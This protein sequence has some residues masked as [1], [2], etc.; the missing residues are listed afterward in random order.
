MPT[1]KQDSSFSLTKM[2]RIGRVA[3]KGTIITLVGLMVGRM[4]VT[5]GYNYWKAT[6][7]DPPPPPTA[8][9]GILPSLQFP[10]QLTTEKPTSYVLETPTGKFSSFGDRA[11]VFLMTHPDPSL[12]AD[13][14][15]RRVAAKLGFVGEPEIIGSSFYRWTKSEP[16]LTT[17]DLDINTLHFTVTTDYLSRPDILYASQL[18][19]NFDAV[20]NVKSFLSSSGLLPSDAATSSGT[21]AML[22]A[23]GTDFVKAV[24]LSDANVLQVAIHRSPI[25]DAYA[26]F[27]PNDNKGTISGIVGSE[28][29][30]NSILEFSFAHHT[31]DYAQMHTYFIRSPEAAWQVLKAGEGYIAH[32]GTTDQ[33]VIRSVELGYYDSSDE[34]SY[35]QPI[36]VFSGDDDFLGYVSAIDPKFIQTNR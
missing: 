20:K 15:A 12:L 9:F 17:L 4:V 18:P 10:S 13:E 25:D 2:T 16:L 31:V 29:V 26:V 23:S 6:H 11:K 7:P 8:G 35:L 1:T 28:G 33:A 19:T 36:Y 34:Q 27:T 30:D 21:V 3:V 22:K 32:K 14:N 5:A 24:S